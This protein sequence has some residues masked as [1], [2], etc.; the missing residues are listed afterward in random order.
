MSSIFRLLYRYLCVQLST[1]MDRLCEQLLPSL[2][3][4]MG[5]TVKVSTTYTHRLT[6]VA[7]S[8]LLV[9]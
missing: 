6:I 8:M 9:R 1:K 5:A 3:L 7:V 2:I 4:L